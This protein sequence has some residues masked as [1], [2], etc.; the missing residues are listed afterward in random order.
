MYNIQPWL[1]RVQACT[2]RLKLQNCLCTE[3]FLIPLFWLVQ[4]G[5]QGA[6][7]TNNTRS[8][9]AH[10]THWAGL[11]LCPTQTKS[12]L[13]II[14]IQSSDYPG[15]WLSMGLMWTLC[16]DHPGGDGQTTTTTTGAGESADI[17]TQ[18]HHYPLSGMKLRL[19][20]M[21]LIWY[22]E[23]R[24]TARKIESNDFIF[25]VLQDVKGQQVQGLSCS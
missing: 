14:G 3:Q 19:Q 13:R 22:E 10:C 18:Y 1:R 25:A 8:H 21:T 17:I 6:D 16:P 23:L 12:V 15:P 24:L 7:I 2:S 5:S 4:T 11:N 9:P 20:A